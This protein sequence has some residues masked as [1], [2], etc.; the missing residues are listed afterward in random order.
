MITLPEKYKN[1][2][3]SMFGIIGE[4]WIANVPKIIDKY[5]KKFN[6]KNI[7]IPNDFTY[8]IILFADS[9]DFGQV[10]L[11]AE[12][13]FK[14]MTLRESVALKLNDGKGA[15]KCYYSNID[16][17]ILII[18]RLLPGKSLNTINNIDERIKVF[19][20]VASKFNIRVKDSQGLPSYRE[21]LNRSINIA[22]NDPQKF[23]PVK[24]LLSVAN[25]IYN[26]IEEKN[27]SNYLLHSDL[28]CDNILTTNDGWKTIDPHGFIGEKILDSAIFIMKELENSNFS[29]D[30]ICN[31][32]TLMGKYYDSD[33]LELCKALFVNY[34]LNVCWDIE[35]NLDL[36]YIE[37]CVNKAKTILNYLT[38]QTLNNQ[39]QQES[40]SKKLIK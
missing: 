28:Y 9:K 17:G 40:N 30:D 2:V 24:N 12:I 35:V 39:N 10:V 5:I 21:I 18:E 20:E 14:E 32:L 36:K 4:N 19:S 3:V 31:I 15:C 7:K 22:N 29:S 33:E 16:D 11:K 37:D 34:V 25:S 27:D 23:K 8:N 1:N 13:P 6:L 38:N 26:E